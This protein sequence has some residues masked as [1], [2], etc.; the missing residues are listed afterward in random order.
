MQLYDS[1]HSYFVSLFCEFWSIVIITHRLRIV[2]SSKSFIHENIH[3]E[4]S[5][6]FMVVIRTI[7]SLWLLLFM[8]WLLEVNILT[9]AFVHLIFT[10]VI[11]FHVSW[12]CW[13]ILVLYATSLGD[14][15]AFFFFG[16]Q[17]ACWLCHHQHCF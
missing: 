4:C 15:I 9:F 13:L 5:N 1:F 8:V 3:L 17:S 2:L 14:T 7:I 10:S 11:A 12:S 6:I 16:S